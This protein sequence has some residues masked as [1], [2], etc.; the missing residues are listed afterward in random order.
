[1]KNRTR[2]RHEPR[3]VEL[4][5]AF[6]DLM[7]HITADYHILEFHP[8]RGDVQLSVPPESLVGRTITEVVPD[9]APLFTSGVSEAL[10][11][12]KIVS[13]MYSVTID[14]RMRWRECRYVPTE[15]HDV[16]AFVRDLTDTWRN[17]AAADVVEAIPDLVYR[18]SADFRFIDL[19]LG[20]PGIEPIKPPEELLGRTFDE[21]FTDEVAQI[22]KSAVTEALSTGE[23]VTRRYTVTIADKNRLRECRFVPRDNEEVLGFV[24][25]LTD[26]MPDPAATDVVQ[27]IPDLVYRFSADFR[28][29]EFRRD[30]PDVEPIQPPEKFLGKTFD[31]VMTPEFA[32]AFKSRVSDALSTG[33]TV[34]YRY[35]VTIA[36]RERLRE[37]RFVPLN[38][39][40]IG[41][42][43]DLTDEQIDA[44]DRDVG[45]S[46]QDMAF[47]ISRDFRYL[48]FLPGANGIQPIL[49]PE[50]FLG[51]TMDELGS[52]ELAPLFKSGVTE[53]LRTG[54][55]VKRTYT[56]RVD[57][58]RRWREC[59]YVPTGED[60]VTAFVRELGDDRRDAADSDVV[61]ASRESV[62]RVSADFRVLEFQPGGLQVP[63]LV[64]PE[65]FL[66]RTFDEIFPADLAELHKSAVSEALRTGS[67]V[68]RTFV[69]TIEGKRRWRESRYIPTENNE[70][71]AFVRDIT[72]DRVELADPKVVQAIPDMIFRI[73][74]DFRYLDFL[75]GSAGLQPY[76][77]PETFLGR[78][79]D[80]IMPADVAEQSKSWIVEALTHG[81]DR[82]PDLHPADRR[83]APSLRVRDCSGRNRRGRRFREGVRE[84]PGSA[85]SETAT[86]RRERQRLRARHIR[87]YGA[88]AHRLALPPPGCNGQ[89]DLRPAWHQ[90]FH[91]EQARR[92][93]P[94]QDEG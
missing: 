35:T 82:P 49:P 24:R 44:T 32:Q 20:R 58:R 65:E 66:G 93:H 69:V 12:G 39:E 4:V 22:Y 92:Q 13:R 14:G 56:V 88:R 52:S 11:T 67:A 73:S 17:P 10:S 87:P 38:N 83:Y 59:R 30:R 18:F 43:R 21:V 19:R 79:V 77:P 28:F 91:R 85:H 36:G 61:D 31:E 5:D 6:P 16:I 78:T 40:V 86:S 94:Q 29:I 72:D 41:F 51:R 53:A 74:R 64:P 90:R 47:R 37:C 8:G 33:K 68:K 45:E 60:E 76:V 27:A 75:P 2:P 42:V 84:R 55:T 1:M 89:G 46:N 7:F 3:G 15:N 9:L 70:V 54:K 26:T 57:G 23:S 71:I 81:G 63:P 34:T 62:V 50:E 25:D 48:E 80:E